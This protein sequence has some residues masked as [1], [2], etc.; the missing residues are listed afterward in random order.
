LTADPKKIKAHFS[1]IISLPLTNGQQLLI[2]KLSKFIASDQQKTFVLKGYAG[3]GKTTITGYL[4]KTLPTLK[5]KSVL[6]APTGRAAK[7]L[8][9]HAE[10]QALTI[11]KKIY[12]RNTEID[13]GLITL[14]LMKNLHTNT[15]FIVDEA[16]M[17][18]DSPSRISNVF[19]SRQLLSDLISYVNSGK[20]CKLILIGDNAQLPPVGL[21]DSPA[22]IPENLY[23][24]LFS[25][26]DSIELKEVVRQTS[27]SGIL[28]NATSIRNQIVNER[29]SFP[30]IITD[31]F[32]D[33][34]RVNG[35]D[36]QEE[37]ESAY[38]K[39]ER[40]D[41]III[42]RSNKRANI[43]NQEVR[44]RILWM[45]NEITNGDLLMVVK[46]NYYWLDDESKAGFIANGDTLEIKRIVRYHEIYGFRF[47]DIIVKMVDY[48]DEPEFETRIILDS[49][50]VDAAALPRDQI[51][52]F[53]YDIYEDYA[54]ERNKTKRWQKV[55]NDPF[56][57]ALQ[58]KFSYAVTCHKS[59][60][61]QWPLVFLDQGYLTDEMINLEFLRWLY[62]A[63]TRATER[64]YLIN[65]NKLFFD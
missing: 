18:P 29:F 59:Q 37:L 20:N 23:N 28:F 24:P 54:E 26:I 33:V 58:V 19:E 60:G 51:K 40:K 43:Y 62:T 22:L 42:C 52:K 21:D 61:G 34:V 25:A 46:N 39:H 10:K 16:S 49:L 65:F 9:L 48:P 44:A 5:L 6:L 64:I 47:A 56:C 35:N 32:T 13:R 38:G 8:A 4:V 14:E 1:K 41:V 11:H 30:K 57:N 45:E 3:T 50:M 55:F 63:I 12:R 17:I 53:Y 27:S 7:V 15:I 2:E 31:P 36:L